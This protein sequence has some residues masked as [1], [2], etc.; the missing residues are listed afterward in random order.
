M[1]PAQQALL[2]F[3]VVSA[4]LPHSGTTLAA[5][6]RRCGVRAATANALF[7][8]LREHSC[9]SI[10]FRADKNRRVPLSWAAAD[11]VELA[12]LIRNR[13]TLQ[14]IDLAGSALGDEN[15]ILLAAG[16]GAAVEHGCREIN[17]ENVRLGDNG[18]V[19]VGQAVMQ[20]L[21]PSSEPPGL[22]LHLGDNLITNAGAAAILGF[23]LGHL[24]SLDLRGNQLTD[25]AAWGIVASVPTRSSLRR[26][27]LS[28]NNLGSN[29]TNALLALR[30]R[31]GDHVDV[32][33][34]GQHNDT[35]AGAE[36]Q[37]SKEEL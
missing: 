7:E 32:H 11:V 10:E 15:A 13:P 28:G 8:E 20:A 1:C 27:N 12:H 17:L 3:G 34:E 14:K 31:D 24:D 19:A 29:V 5:P 36:H 26:L 16:L 33:A 9:S 35:S 4:L 23:T 37:Y 21:G 18:L 6:L 30:N 22:R 2:Y 25:K